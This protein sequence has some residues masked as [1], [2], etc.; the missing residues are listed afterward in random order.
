MRRGKGVRKGRERGQCQHH[1]ESASGKG[2]TKTLLRPPKDK[3]ASLKSC[4]ETKKDDEQ[5]QKEQHK[6]KR[7]RGR[8]GRR[9]KGAVEEKT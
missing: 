3:A 2:N 6:R 1:C 4:Q 5:S 8:R 7:K 9:E